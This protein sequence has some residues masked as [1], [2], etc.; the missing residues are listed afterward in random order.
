M[1]VTDWSAYAPYFTENEFKC[2]HTGK[3]LMQKEFMDKLYQIRK[4]FGHPMKISSGY[5]DRTHPIEAK[6]STVGEHT[7]G[8]CADIAVRGGEAHLILLIALNQGILRVGVQQKGAGRFLHLGM[9]RKHA[10]PTI[11]SY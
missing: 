3:C 5:R 6:K 7:T 4:A 10:H 2:K 9:S 11:W 8:M 1:I